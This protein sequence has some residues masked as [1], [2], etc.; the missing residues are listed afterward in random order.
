MDNYNSKKTRIAV[1]PNICKWFT[2]LEKYEPVSLT[3]FADS[4][5]QKQPY[6]LYNSTFCI[7]P[8]D[9]ALPFAIDIYFYSTWG[10]LLSHYLNTSDVLF[11]INLHQE[12]CNSM[13]KWPL[14]TTIDPTITNDAYFQQIQ[15][16]YELIHAITQNEEKKRSA[17]YWMVNHLPSIEF[18]CQIYNDM[19]TMDNTIRNS[20]VKIKIDIESRKDHYIFHWAADSNYFSSHIVKQMDAHYHRLLNHMLCVN[21]RYEY[22]TAAS[23]QTPKEIKWQENQLSGPNVT[24]P[25]TT[26]PQWFEKQAEATPNNIALVYSSQKIT[27]AALNSKANQV[28]RFLINNGVIPNDIVALCFEH[29]IDAI[30][31]IMGI[32]KAGATYLPL[33]PADTTSRKQAILCQAHPVMLIAPSTILTKLEKIDLVQTLFLSWD[34]HV[35][36]VASTLPESNIKTAIDHLALAYIMYTSGST[37]VPKGVMVTHENVINLLIGMQPYFPVKTNSRCSLFSKL[38][39]DVSVFEIFSCILNGGCLYL[40]GP[41]LRQAPGQLMEILS[42]HQI[43]HTYIPPFYLQELLEKATKDASKMSLQHLLVSVEPVRTKLLLAIKEKLSINIANAYGPT[44]TTIFTTV[45]TVNSLIKSTYVP[46]GKPLCNTRLFIWDQFNQ[47]LASGI[48]GELYIAGTGVTKGYLNDREQTRKNYIAPTNVVAQHVPKYRTGDYVRLLPCGN[49]EFLGRRDNQVKWHG[50]R[51]ELN[52]IKMTIQKALKVEQAYVALLEAD[53]KKQLVLYLIKQTSV[54]TFTIDTIRHK[55]FAYLPSYMMPTHLV[56]INA[57]PMTANGKLDKSALP[58][59]ALSVDS[60]LPAR[61]ALDQSL[62]E[63]WQSILAL[64]TIGRQDNFFSLGGHSLTGT[65]II[66]AINVKHKKELTLDNLYQHPTIEQLSDFIEKDISE[67]QPPSLGT[68]PQAG[69]LFPLSHAQKRLWFMEQYLPSHARYNIFVAYELTGHLEYKSLYS[70]FCRLI[71]QYVSLR[72]SFIKIN[73]KPHQQIFDELP[74]PFKLPIEN[75]SKANDKAIY[76]E[77]YQ[78]AQTT[79]NLTKAP[80]LR[81]RL[82]ILDEEHH[83]L[84]LTIHHI[85]CDGTSYNQLIKQLTIFYAEEVQE[86]ANPYKKET[87]DYID[88]TLWEQSKK[89]CQYIETYLKNYV[90]S[91]ALLQPLQLSFRRSSKKEITPYGKRIPFIITQETTSELRKKSIQYNTSLFTILYSAF[92][93]LLARYSG[94][95]DILVTTLFSGRTE[96]SLVSMFGFFVNLVL[97]RSQLSSETTFEAL[98]EQ[99]HKNMLR[100]HAEFQHVPFDKLIAEL[101]PERK[102][103]TP[104]TNI[105]FIFQNFEM[106]CFKGDGLKTKRTYTDN[107]ALLG[108]DFETSKFE[109]AFYLQEHDDSLQGLVEYN[110]E[111]FHESDMREF[112]YHF[113]NILPTLLHAINES[114][115]TVPLLTS[116]ETIPSQLS[117]SQP[118]ADSPEP[119]QGLSYLI[120]KHAVKTPEKIALRFGDNAITYL[121]LNQ[122]ANQVAHQL[123]KYSLPKE[124]HIALCMDRHPNVL[125]GM[126]GIL[127]AGGAYVPIEPDYPIANITYILKDSNTNVLITQKK[128]TEKFEAWASQPE[129]QLIIIETLLETANKHPKWRSN[130]NV[131]LPPEQLAYLMYTSGSTGK[132]KGVMIEHRHVMQLIS[133][134]S[135]EFKFSSDDVWSLAHSIVFDISAGEIWS[136]WFH[137]G[138]LVI[139]PRCTLQNRDTM[140]TTLLSHGITILAQT[141]SMFKHIFQAQHDDLLSFLKN[142]ALHHIL[143]CG[144]ELNMFELQNTLQHFL[145]NNIEMVNLYGPTETTIYATFC[146]ITTELLSIQQKGSAIGKAFPY[147]KTKIVDK[148]LQAVPPGI[149]GELVIEGVSVARG[150]WNRPEIQEKRFLPINTDTPS[151]KTCYCTGD[152]CY[153]SL[154]GDLYFVGRNDNQI[155]LLGHRIELD[156]IKH[157]L[158]T[159]SDVIDATVII[160]TNNEQPQLT[161][162]IVP[163]DKRLKKNNIKNSTIQHWQQLYENVYQ[164][165]SQDALFNISGWN[166]SF[167]GEAIPQEEM[168]DWV[169]QTVTRIQAFKPQ[170]ILEIGCGTGLLLFKLIPQCSCYH[171][172]DFSAQALQLVRKGLNAIPEHKYKV[173]LFQ[174]SANEPFPI[175][176]KYDMIII[177]SVVQYFPS[178]AF[179]LDVLDRAINQLTEKGHCFIGDVR[180]LEH[181]PQF[182][183]SVIQSQRKVSAN[184]PTLTVHTDMMYQQEEELV[185]DHRFFINYAKQHSRQLHACV[186]LKISGYD[187]EMVTYR[188][189]AILSLTKPTSPETIEWINQSGK[190]LSKSQW[191]TYVKQHNKKAFAIE[192]VLYTW[193]NQPRHK[194]QKDNKLIWLSQ[195][196]LMSDYLIQVEWSRQRPNDCIDIVAAPCGQSIQVST[197][198]YENMTPSAST[199]H[200]CSV[201][202]QAIARRQLLSKLKDSLSKQLPRHMVPQRMITLEKLPTTISGKLDTRCLQALLIRSVKQHPAPPQNDLEKK[203][204]EIWSYVLQQPVSSIDDDFF[205]LG[206]HSLLAVVLVQKMQDHGLPTISVAD[207]ITNK[208]IRKI[209]K[210]ASNKIKT[211]STQ[212]SRKKKKV[213]ILKVE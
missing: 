149:I 32:L 108:A 156:E 96:P 8:N 182:Y 70:A 68:V 100:A 85:I 43:T 80:L 81:A 143:F 183:R 78:E 178:E 208:T 146:R 185:I 54:Q 193:P 199:T 2:S 167:T 103:D 72:T 176:I 18:Y 65:R 125:I 142:T 14:R 83:L 105:L 84:L 52:A 58:L 33:D 204:V 98:L 36:P 109:L 35:F 50:H 102:N 154:S 184:S 64:E 67:Y 41:T 22:L 21:N 155:K 48:I 13:I 163:D 47:P 200:Y 61:H 165:E 151:S 171:A 42:E 121:T 133:Q 160:D 126:V 75:F 209:A 6:I 138:T 4:D 104:L 158:L 113:Q 192:Q 145:D 38:N 46:I 118:K 206:G 89:Q 27:Y 3:P 56:F 44:E 112:I 86:N 129:H 135:L 9:S 128:Y 28:A 136:A 24:L 172:I 91:L 12:N 144:E 23:I 211:T 170:R 202:Q 201:P 95:E 76:T 124:P 110:K 106:C 168:L 97:L 157:Q 26:L 140:M 111:L 107:H 51:I 174:Q 196:A 69:N 57:W 181:L 153:T 99:N 127:K 189:D 7:D 180:S 25:E 207:L 114:I 92:V 11:N 82:L 197:Y 213:P 116:T 194:S 132:P 198:D 130:P 205:E 161:A 19:A 162:F 175:D 15:S 159:E 186:P 212:K 79:F 115:W 73:G 55:L 59:P 134:L 62:I 10:L 37:G 77:V 5:S 88:Y 16:Q 177:N 31:T 90:N 101:N 29:S 20:T 40:I 195:W 120:E 34:N 94:Q 63:I 141:P 45:F 147:L 179:L 74:E 117:N 203:L 60:P 39:F 187:N 191:Q 17:E 49:L 210:N 87:P 137:G 148:N 169:S 173:Q 123:L 150:Y 139:I 66:Q 122:Q 166:S 190:T 188:Y 152:L 53:N 164:D 119:P 30:I 131:V 1:S 93:V 71:K